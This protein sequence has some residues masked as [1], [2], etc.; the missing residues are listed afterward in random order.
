MKKQNYL[1]ALPLLGTLLLL[2]LSSGCDKSNGKLYTVYEPVYA[3]RSSVMASINGN[4]SRSIDSVG[5]IYVKGSYIFLN[6]PDNGIHVID[7]HNPTHPV[8]TAFLS[9]P[10][11]QDIAIKDN[12]LYA[13]MYDELLAIDITDIH[14]VKVPGQLSQLFTSRAYVNGYATSGDQ[15]IVG[16]TKHFSKTPPPPIYETGGICPNCA[17]LAYSSSSSPTGTAGSMAK[18]VLVGSQLYTIPERHSLQVVDLENASKP[19]KGANIYAGFDL[20]TIYPFEDKLFLGSQEGVY[21]YDLSDPQHPVS[22]GTFTH[23]RACDPVIT[24]GDYAYVTLHEGT[25]CGG[26]SNELDVVNV[27][28]LSNPLLVKSLP[29]IKPMGLAKDG[30]LLFVCDGPGVK[31]FNTSNPSALQLLTT[32]NTGTTYDVIAS[33]KH[34]V[35]M[36]DK[37]LMQYGYDKPGIPLLSI[38]PLG[39]H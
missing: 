19:S 33:D 27:K 24:D 32:L 39:R 38:M 31:V 3:S 18:M 22:A 11:T 29:M 30:N 6:E 15:V 35:V 14:H 5:K 12:I 7:N 36:S 13:D 16:W 21:I 25:S 34:L 26:A 10:G 20:E 2:L 1:T 23:G 4:A 9:I 28:D 8:Q 37:G 17:M